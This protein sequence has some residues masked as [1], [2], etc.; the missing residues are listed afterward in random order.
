MPCRTFRNRIHGVVITFSDIT[1]AR[2]LE[3]ELQATQRTLEGRL[4]KDGS[5]RHR[6]ASGRDRLRWAAGLANLRACLTATCFSG[7]SWSSFP[8]SAAALSRR[9]T[10]MNAE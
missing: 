9:A 8:G 3:F 2:H 5:A 6:R 1:H 10:V 7:V 4:G